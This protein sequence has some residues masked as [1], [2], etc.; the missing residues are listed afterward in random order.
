MNGEC[1]DIAGIQ[2]GVQLGKSPEGASE[3]PP[4][5]AVQPGC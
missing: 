2:Q 3:V 5:P 4:T 1:Y